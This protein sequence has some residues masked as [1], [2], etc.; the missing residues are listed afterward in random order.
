MVLLKSVGLYI[1]VIYHMLGMFVFSA[2]GIAM[3]AAVS[4]STAHLTLIVFVAIMLHKVS[5]QSDVDKQ[6]P[7]TLV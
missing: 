1:D 2:D 3:G 4:M 7:R 5:T 6:H